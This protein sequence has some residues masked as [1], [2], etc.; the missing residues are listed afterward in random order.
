MQNDFTTWKP[1]FGYEAAYEVSDKGSVRSVARYVRTGKHLDRNRLLKPKTIAQSMDSRGYMSVSL[2]TNNS[3]ITCRVHR[4]V[5]MAF[6]PND[7]HKRLDINHIDGDK[8][9]NRISN[10]EWCT[11]GENHKHRYRVL[12][13]AHSFVGRVGKLHARSKPVIGVHTQTGEQVF[14]ESASQAG[15]A[16]NMCFSRICACA[17]G[18]RGTHKKYA[19]RWAGADDLSIE[20]SNA[21]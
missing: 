3:A 17:R 4:L 14:F 9:N 8:T 20:N 21:C 7:D 10:L 18:E 11:R 13:Q 2:W 19:W 1:V 12:G 5:A 16:M 6:M 15:L